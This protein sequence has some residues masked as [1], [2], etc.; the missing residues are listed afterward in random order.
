[1]PRAEQW[2]PTAATLLVLAALAG[3]G[4]GPHLQERD[5]M[6]R[7]PIEQVLADHTPRLM[8]LSGVVGTYQGALDDGA[9]CIKV[10]VVAMTASLRDSVPATLEGWPVLIE[11]TGEIRPLGGR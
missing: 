8:A 1:M 4:G 3:C 7:R 6:A 10:M 9:P 5:A 11:E 2:R